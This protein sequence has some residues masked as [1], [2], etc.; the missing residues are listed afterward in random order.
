MSRVRPPP[1]ISIEACEDYIR[2]ETARCRAID[3]LLGLQRACEFV[4]KVGIP[5]QVAQTWA[6]DTLE[7][8]AKDAEAFVAADLQERRLTPAVVEALS[9]RIL[10]AA[11]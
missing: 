11:P 4:A 1:R 5:L 7:Q 10:A 9:D 6:G 2:L 3:D 8:I